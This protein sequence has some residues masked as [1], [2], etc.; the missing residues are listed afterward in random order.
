MH[1]TPG[2]LLERLREPRDQASWARF[3]DLYTPLLFHWARRAGLQEQD[4]AD[5]I[6]DVFRVLVQKLPTF[7]YDHQRS[8][9]GWLHTVLLNQWRTSL[10]RRTTEVPLEDMGTLLTQ[11]GEQDAYI[12]KEY[13][14]YLIKRALQMMQ[15]DFQPLTWQAC[16]Q[17]VA[18][19]RPAAAVA[20]ELGMTVKA[21]YLAKARVLRRLRQELQGLFD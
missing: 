2:S 6:Q 1:S 16:W 11:P 5:L 17:H 19:D 3:V 9:R 12:E 7:T 20:A 10:R 4:A 8:F 15:T 14:S 13:R 18:C 21:V